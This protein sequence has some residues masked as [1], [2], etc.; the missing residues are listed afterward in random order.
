VVFERFSNREDMATLQQLDALFNVNAAERRALRW[1]IADMH[2]VEGERGKA[3]EIVAEL[4]EDK[5]SEEPVPTRERIALVADLV[6]MLRLEGREDDALA[7]I[8][9]WLV[10]GQPGSGETYR[11]EYSP[12]LLE[13]A[14][15]HLAAQRRA[16]AARD[17]QE[18]FQRV[19]AES[20][21][22]AEYAEGRLMEGM[23][24]EDAGKLARPG[25]RERGVIG[26]KAICRRARS[27]RPAAWNRFTSATRS[28]PTPSSPPGP[29]RSPP[30]KPCK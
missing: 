3:L 9:R 19:P 26:M 7:E 5:P 11:E 1:R 8:H 12:L 22:H 24:E 4:I 21:S 18:F 20:I 10:V 25:S 16:E 30:M 13:R 6:W 27:L 28:P 29:A 23:I 14:R 17:L 2:R 15:L